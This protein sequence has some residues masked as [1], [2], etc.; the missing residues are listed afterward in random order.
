MLG[1][2][3]K[4]PAL[5]RASL[6][7]RS[8]RPS[9]RRRS[10]NGLTLDLATNPGLGLIKALEHRMRRSIAGTKPGFKKPA[11]SIRP[12]HLVRKAHQHCRKLTIRQNKTAFVVLAA[13]HHRD[14]LEGDMGHLTRTSGTPCAR[15]SP[16]HSPNPPR[17][18]DVPPSVPTLRSQRG[19][20]Q[21]RSTFWSP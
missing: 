1:T 5:G 14:R 13:G 6:V 19:C 8:K 10:S 21:S 3:Q 9:V 4:G 15:M 17:L 11:A 18:S 20:S 16:S 12:M 2:P 7:V